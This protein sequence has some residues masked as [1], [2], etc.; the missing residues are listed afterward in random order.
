M[1]FLVT[2]YFNFSVIKIGLFE[3][4]LPIKSMDKT[5]SQNAEKTPEKKKTAKPETPKVVEKEDTYG[6]EETKTLPGE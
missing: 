4:S 3:A 1:S 2:F 6:T 5:N